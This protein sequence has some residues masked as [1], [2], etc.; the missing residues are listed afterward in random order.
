MLISYC[1]GCLEDHS[2]FPLLGMPFKKIPKTTVPLVKVWEH[3]AQKCGLLHSVYAVNGDKYT[4][5]WLDNKK[6]GN[7]LGLLSE[8]RIL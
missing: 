3:K 8:K 4:G 2:I 6:H 1:D 7:L 5:E